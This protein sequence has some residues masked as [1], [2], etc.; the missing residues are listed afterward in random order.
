VFVGDGGFNS[1]ETR[2]YTGQ[3]VCPFRLTSKVINGHTYSN[4]PT[5]RPNYGSSS[6]RAYNAVFSANAFAWC[7][8]K[9]EEWRR[10]HK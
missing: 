2:T 6:G 5:Y 9:A 4:Y 8:E 1:G 7:I 3:T 10:A